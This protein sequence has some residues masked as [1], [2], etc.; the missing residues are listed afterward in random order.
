M[1][2]Q[3]L[4]EIT[5][6][7][8]PSVANWPRRQ[9]GIL[10]VDGKELRYGDLHSFYHQSRQIFGE[11]LYD[12]ESKNRAPV[13]LDCGAHIGLASLYFKER[14]PEAHIRAFEADAALADFC[15]NNLIAFGAKD[16]VIED[17]AV[18]T[19]DRGVNFESSHDDSGHITN[20]HNGTLVRSVQLRSVLDEG[21]FVILKLDV[22][23]A[24]FDILKDCGKSLRNVQ[25]LIVE[26]HAMKDNQSKIGELLENLE[27]QDFRY[28]L[29]DL[30]QAIWMPSSSPPPFRH[31]NTEKF[32]VTVF[33]WH[34][35][36]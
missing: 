34:A 13:I 17:A 22:E 6:Q 10:M 25:N 33:A 30:H 31:C 23:G 21:P 5:K 27:N 12:F 36:N 26:V 4:L 2:T 29:G 7:L 1:L 35:L 28:V 15:K 20:A 16:V 14:Y 24:E 8:A 9:P 32:I 3:S 18:W 19:H 11:R